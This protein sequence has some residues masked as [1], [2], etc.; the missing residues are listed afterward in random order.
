MKFSLS[1]SLMV[2]MPEK[3]ELRKGLFSR[4]IPE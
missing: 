4:I 3:P 1:E 2:K